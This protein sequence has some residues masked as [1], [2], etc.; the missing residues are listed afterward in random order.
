MT[1]QL[2]LRMLENTL[3][4]K[5]ELMLKYDTLYLMGRLTESD[6]TD[7]MNKLNPPTVEEIIEEGVVNE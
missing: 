6:Y 1:Y 4:T 5:E 7:L 3:Y 2:C